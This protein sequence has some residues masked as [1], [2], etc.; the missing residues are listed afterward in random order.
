MLW[1]VLQE[2]GAG[3]KRTLAGFRRSYERVTGNSFV[4]S[5]FY[6]RFNAEL[7]RMFCAVLRE[8]MTKLAASGSALRRRAGRIP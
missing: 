8:L 4:P 3:R 6:D 1:S 7:A 5:S 2:F